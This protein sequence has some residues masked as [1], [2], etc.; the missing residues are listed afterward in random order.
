MEISSLSL[1]EPYILNGLL[2]VWSSTHS[3]PMDAEVGTFTWNHSGKVGQSFM[4]LIKDYIKQSWL[5][6]NAIEN[7]KIIPFKSKTKLI[8]NYHSKSL[9]WLLST[10][11]C[12]LR[13]FMLCVPQVSRYISYQLIVLSNQLHIQRSITLNQNQAGQLRTNSIWQISK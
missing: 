5:I 6:S 8:H 11:V 10:L 2:K 4:G 12:C 3:T 9:Q 7:T 1:R 13:F